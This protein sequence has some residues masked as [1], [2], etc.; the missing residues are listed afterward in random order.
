MAKRKEGSC[1]KMGLTTAEDN[2]N[3]EPACKKN[4]NNKN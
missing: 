2:D 3:D 1:S 4:K